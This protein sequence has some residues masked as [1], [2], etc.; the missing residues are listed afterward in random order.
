MT[1]A[2]RVG[3]NCYEVPPG[4]T[5]DNFVAFPVRSTDLTKKPEYLSEDRKDANYLRIPLDSPLATAGAGG[6]LPSY[7]GPWSPGLSP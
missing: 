5:G 6:D 4:E 3:H 7:I 1:S 2:W